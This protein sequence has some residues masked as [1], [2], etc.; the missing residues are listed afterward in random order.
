MDGHIEPCYL[1]PRLAWCS[2]ADQT[3]GLDGLSLCGLD[4]LSLRV[5]GLK[6]GGGDSSNNRHGFGACLLGGFLG[7]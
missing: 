7:V 3:D 6:G 5:D 2:R 1:R 4:G